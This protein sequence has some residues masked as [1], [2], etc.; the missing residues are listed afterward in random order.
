MTSSSGP[1]FHCSPGPGERPSR[2]RVGMRCAKGLAD[3]RGP[4]ELDSTA[5]WFS[6]D[7][8]SVVVTG[9]AVVVVVGVGLSFGG[10]REISP[11]QAK[12]PIVD[13]A[14]RP[15]DRVWTRRAIRRRA[16]ADEGDQVQ[17]EDSGGGILRLSSPASSSSDLALATK[18]LTKVV[19]KL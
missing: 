7:V 17:F 1:D 3:E 14:I 12:R 10:A 11:T 2:D 9:I 8:S 4:V 15:A 6:V 5:S 13:A 19:G 18:L 16:L